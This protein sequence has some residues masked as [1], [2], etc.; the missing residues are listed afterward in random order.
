MQIVTLQQFLAMPAGTIY[1][2]TTHEGTF[3]DF[4]IKLETRGDDDWDYL[5]LSPCNFEL[6]ATDEYFKT[7]DGMKRGAVANMEFEGVYINSDFDEFEGMP[8]TEYLYAVYSKADI[9][10]LVRQFQ[11][12]L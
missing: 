5:L 10:M 9:E 11:K 6:N 8:A 2:R 3:S 1:A 4:E 12:F 7:L